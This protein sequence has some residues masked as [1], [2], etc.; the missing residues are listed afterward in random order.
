MSPLAPA[1]A[2]ALA[3]ALSGCLAPTPSPAVPAEEVPSQVVLWLTESAF[4]AEA[5]TGEEPV[6]VPS[7]NFF[8]AWADGEGLPTWRG[9]AQAQDLRVTSARV[10]AWAE[11]PR[12]SAQAGRFPSYMAYL[13]AAGFL[14]AQ[15]SLPPLGVVA[16]GAVHELV[17][18]LGLPEGGLVVPAGED[19]ELL[20]TPVQ[21]NDDRAHA[22]DFLVDAVE[23]PSRIEL[24]VEPFPLPRAETAAE[25]SFDGRLAGTAYAPAPQPT[26][27][28]DHAFEVP[29]GTVRVEVTMEVL[30]NV[31]FPDVDLA[32]LEGETELASS[33][34]PYGV[35]AVRLYPAAL[36]NVTLPTT[37]VARVAEYGST[38]AEYRVTVTTW[39]E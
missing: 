24:D 38:T 22:I 13:G 28:A 1:L 25:A 8:E 26:Q 2:L 11:V 9:G 36:R 20:L 35:E 34:T 5:P 7:G 16:P 33:V 15:E 19:L 12:G 23:T 18:D 3:L 14:Q 21:T 32:V 39:T 30:S 29:A 4:R 27:T 17:F 10:Y 6:R 37:L 31:G